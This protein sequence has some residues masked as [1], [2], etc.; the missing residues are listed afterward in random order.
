[1][2]LLRRANQ[3]TLDERRGEDIDLDWT[4]PLLFPP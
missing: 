2:S 3:D 4:V 1:M